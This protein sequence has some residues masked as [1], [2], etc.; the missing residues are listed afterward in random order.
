MDKADIRSADYVVWMPGSSNGPPS[1]A[2]CP[3][4]R[5]IVIDF[6]D[7]HGPIRLSEDPNAYGF[8]FKRSWVR[9]PKGLS[10]EPPS[11][12]HRRA[13]FP[14]SY[15]LAEEFLMREKGSVFTTIRTHPVVCTLRSAMVSRAVDTR[16]NVLGWVGEL[17]DKMGLRKDSIVGEVDHGG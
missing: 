7:G 15:S 17:M 9:K 14:I 11:S 2:D 3:R 6:A 12:A 4:R 10:G 1:Q 8:Y 13:Y 5:L 16:R